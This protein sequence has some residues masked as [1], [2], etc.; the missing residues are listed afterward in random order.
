[1]VGRLVFD[2]RFQDIDIRLHFSQPSRPEGAPI[3]GISK[4]SRI[5]ASA[6]QL[7]NSGPRDTMNPPFRPNHIVR[8]SAPFRAELRY[9]PWLDLLFGDGEAQVAA[10]GLPQRSR[11]VGERVGTRAVGQRRRSAGRFPNWVECVEDDT[12]QDS[13]SSITAYGVELDR[14]GRSMGERG[15]VG[16]P[17]TA[18]PLQSVCESLAMVGR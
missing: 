17:P 11:W 4:T 10:L 9:I 16:S 3:L 7:D 12:R 1:M 14:I 15:S 8:E 18:I 5:A 6:R 2:P 13:S